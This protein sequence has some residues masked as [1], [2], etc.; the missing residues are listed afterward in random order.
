MS[1]KMVNRT[2][3]SNMILHTRNCNLTHHTR[4]ALIILFHIMIYNASN[5]IL[6]LQCDV[7]Y[8]GGAEGE[9]AARECWSAN[10]LKKKQEEQEI[11]RVSNQIVVDDFYVLFFILD[12][13]LLF[14]S[15]SAFLSSLLLTSPLPYSTF[16]DSSTSPSPAILLSS[17]LI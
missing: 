12:L 16:L 3:N 1:H 10:Q 7:S 14:I 9:V 11:G 4:T 5:S 13:H 8:I 17:S 15:S 2:F 6:I